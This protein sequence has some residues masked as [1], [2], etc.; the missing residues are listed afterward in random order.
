MKTTYESIFKKVYNFKNY[1][2]MIKYL[3]IYIKY[4]I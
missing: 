4:N 3:K 2:V 1:I